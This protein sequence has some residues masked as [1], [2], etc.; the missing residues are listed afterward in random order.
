[1]QQDGQWR[2]GDTSYL[3][4]RLARA[5][6]A[7]GRLPGRGGPRDG[8]RPAAPAQLGD[9][10]GEKRSATELEADEVGAS[11]EWATAKVERTSSR[12]NGERSSGR[13]RQAE[14]GGDFNNGPPF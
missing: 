8:H 6:R 2:D 3:C 12:G 11:L 5:G 4:Q 7:P 9:P 1:M 14:R 10:E 13:E